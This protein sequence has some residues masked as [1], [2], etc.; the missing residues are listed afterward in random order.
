[1]PRPRKCRKVCKIPDTNF[2]GPIGGQKV[3]QLGAQATGEPTVE[4][5]AEPTTESTAEANG[6][7]RGTCSQNIVWHEGQHCKRAQATSDCVTLLV[8]EYEAIRLIDLENMTQEACAEKMHIARTTV[9]AMYNSARRKIADV[10]VHGKHLRIEGGD[11]SVCD[12]VTACGP[13]CHSACPK[14]LGMKEKGTVSSVDAK[15]Q[16]KIYSREMGTKQGAKTMPIIAISS[17]GPTLGDWVDPR[18]GRAGGFIVVNMDTDEVSYVDNGAAQVMSQGAGIETASRLADLGVSV[19]ISGYVGPKAFQA[20]E[21]AEIKICQDVQGVTTGE[22][23]EQF[24]A[25][26]LVY[27]TES[28]K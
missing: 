2:F 28:N 25:G 18:F 24:R 10:L 23:L 7:D 6:A 26:K 9:Q 3:Y 4:H 20:L 5:A 21:A 13:H 12:G 19:V 27:A 8:D 11:Y 15:V 14:F 17:D 22:A 16:K 1:M